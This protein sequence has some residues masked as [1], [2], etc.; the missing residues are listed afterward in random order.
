MRY[1]IGSDERS[2]CSICLLKDRGGCVAA[3]G[4]EKRRCLVS[5]LVL[6]SNVKDSDSWHV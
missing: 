2:S 5:T 1:F 6:Y 3:I 4:D